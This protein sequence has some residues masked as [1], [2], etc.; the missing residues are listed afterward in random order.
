MSLPLSPV[1]SFEPAVSVIHSRKDEITWKMDKAFINDDIA[2]NLAVSTE[3]VRELSRKIDMADSTFRFAE[4][5]SWNKEVY[6]HNTPA[7]KLQSH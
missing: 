4:T 7:S 5:M 2:S 1:L 3:D 6:L